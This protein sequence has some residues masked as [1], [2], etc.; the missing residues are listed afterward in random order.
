MTAD[1]SLTNGDVFT[2]ELAVRS[3]PKGTDTSGC[4]SE[5]AKEPSTNAATNLTDSGRGF[6]CDTRAVRKRRSV[7]LL[8]YGVLLRDILVDTLLLSWC[9]RTT[10]DLDGVG[11]T[12]R[13]GLNG[14]DGHV[15]PS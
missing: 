2:K 7:P 4:S 6:F 3:L 5:R 15:S 12:S 1:C 14:D 13:R 10:T 11:C 8:E 9:R